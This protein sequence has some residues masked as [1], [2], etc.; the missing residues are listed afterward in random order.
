MG[1]SAVAAGQ[2]GDGGRFQLFALQLTLLVF[3]EADAVG[4][5]ALLGQ[6]VALVQQGLPA[7]SGSAHGGALGL[8]A[9]KGVQQRQLAGPRQQRL[10]VMLAVDFDQEGG[11]LGQL[12]HRYRAA[13]DE[14]A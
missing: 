4:D 2:I 1:L 13:I 6:R 8:V 3:Q 10:L 12:R 14:G 11:Q 5:V 9:G 7:G